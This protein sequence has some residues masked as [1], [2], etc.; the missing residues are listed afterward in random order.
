MKKLTDQELDS[1]FKNAADG[2]EP[3]FDQAAWD[4]MNAKL[5]K[6]N[7]VSTLWKRWIPFAFLG[8]VIFSGGV[9]VGSMLMVRKETT[10]VQQQA[11]PGKNSLIND[12]QRA[13]QKSQAE[14]AGPKTSRLQL[15][16]GKKTTERIQKYNTTLQTKKY[17]QNSNDKEQDSDR[18]A[19]KKA[20]SV[21]PFDETI[22]EADENL[23]T[24]YAAPDSVTKSD[25]QEPEEVS[26][27]TLQ[28]DAD[29][30]KKN[31]AIKVSHAFY[32]RALASPDFSTIDN[33]TATSSGSNYALLLDYQL[34]HRWSVST[35]GIW[36]MK[37]YAS[38][39]ETTY[40]K[41]TADRMVGNCRVLDIPIN[42]YYR[43]LPQ[44]KVSFYAG[45]GLSSYIMLSEDY[46]YTFDSPSGSK[47]FSF[48]IEKENNEWFKMLNVSMG[49]QY[50]VA[51]RFHVQV[52]PFIKT[53]LSGVGEWD[54]KLSSMG[55]FMG[56]KYKL[57]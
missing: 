26:K 42:I 29:E 54:V 20:D 2:Y 38:D 30:E 25:Q 4:T 45:A 21:H 16:E 13:M 35:G 50:Q 55:I 51:N 15:R 27:D 52:E 7:P 56:L 34:T 6:P 43:F 3:A 53:P 33:S 14:T 44:S 39:K 17:H 28:L 49:V 57:N 9:W 47:D 32:L 31:E 36:S 18:G 48:N 10:P 22:A 12:E 46:T 40:G 24:A 23:I 11:E 37:K 19:I 41:Y 1:V 5:D 8:L